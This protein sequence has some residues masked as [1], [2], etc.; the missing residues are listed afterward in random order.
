[1]QNLFYP[2]N[3]S[4]VGASK[5]SSK[6]GHIIAKNI[7]ESG[8][9]GKLFLVNPKEKEILEK[10]VFNQ[11]SALPENLEVAIL[12]I[13]AKFILESLKELAN[14]NLK[15]AIIISAGFK[16]SGNLELE[17]ELIK[18]SQI[19]GIKIIGPNCLGVLNLDS[20]N[21]LS[22]NGSFAF[23]PKNRGRTALISQSGALITSFLDKAD[24]RGFGFSKVVSL[25]NK[26]DLD[27]L[28][29]IQ[30]L[31][32][33]PETS[34]IALYLEGYKRAEK[35]VKFLAGS[36]KPV[37]IIKAGKSEKAKQAIS[38]HTGSVAGNSKVSE[39]YL[40]QVKAIQPKTLEE[41]FSTIF[42]FEK[43]GEI[44]LTLFKRGIVPYDSNLKSELNL[45]SEGSSSANLQEYP[46]LTPQGGNFKLAVLTNAGGAGVLSLDAMQ[47]TNL[48]LAKFSENTKNKLAQFLPP[49]SSLNNPVDILGDSKEDRYTNSLK[50]LLEDEKVH[51]ILILLTPQV[52]TE[53]EKTAQS[54]S[55]LSQKYPNKVLLPV[56][57][58]GDKL[59]PAI[60]IFRKNKIPY[61]DTP[62]EAL[63]AL[64]NFNRFVLEE[65]NLDF[66][67][68]I[69]QETK[70]FNPDLEI[71]LVQIQDSK[72]NNLVTQNK[73]IKDVKNTKI[74][75]QNYNPEQDFLAT[76]LLPYQ[77]EKIDTSK[78]SLIQTCINQDKQKKLPSLSFE[79]LDLIAKT[80]H[81]PLASFDFIN[82]QNYLE[83]YQKYQTKKTVLKVVSATQLHR[84]D[85]QMVKVDVQNLEEVQAFTTEFRNEKM[86]L[87][88]MITGGI[89]VFIGIQKDPQFGHS[90]VVGS[91][92]I[93]TEILDDLTLGAIPISQNQIQKLFEKTKVWKFLNGYRS[94]FFDTNKLIQTI[95]NLTILVQLFPEIQSIDINPFI[96]TKEDGFLVDFKILI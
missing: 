89:E 61:F 21:P 45:A 62:D 1:M 86:I 36:K 55:D 35:L 53:V 54:I 29:F 9:K 24:R 18:F 23:L 34:V 46:P 12:V 59:H 25:G 69:T 68:V 66:L 6:L 27:E 41:F 7:L 4:I 52:N 49:T 5:D 42:L 26:A 48:K 88:E 57:L 28:D 51:Y 11:I 78:L 93:Y 63:Q 47:N 58:G 85:K 87:Q 8:Y 81:L 13:P 92:G 71:N 44:P 31:E 77:K 82:T 84:T 43:Y 16:E 75:L 74:S 73:I 67:E 64:N 70:I 96:A 60:E 95:Y 2:K 80:F 30:F 79:T 3:L 76:K 56:F 15:Y 65:K 90:L 32:N 37:V 20:K 83:I 91:G 10:E 72:N 40:D 50:V 39:M 94:K 38:S 33:D 14:K 22:Y 17:E 19:S